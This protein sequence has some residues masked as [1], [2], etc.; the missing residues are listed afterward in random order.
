[1]E[2]KQTQLDNGLTIIGEVSNH[3]RSLALG[4]FVRTGARDETA[5][6]SG[7]SHFLEHMLFKGTDKRSALEVNLEFDEMGAK[8]NAFTTEEN[9]VYFAAVLPEYQQRVLALWADLMRPALRDDDF[10]IEKGVILEEIAMYKDLPHFDIIDHARKLHFGDHCCGHTVL[11]SN[12]SITALTAGQM[13]DYFN[14]RYAPDNIVLAC[15]GR[16]DWPSL[17]AQAKELCGSW[18]SMQSKRPLSTVTGTGATDV[19]H[20]AKLQRQH[21]CLVCPAPSEQD[22]LRYPANILS[23]VLGDDSGSRLYWELIDTALADSADMDYDSMDGAGV[24]YTYVSC[25]PEQTSRV[26]ETIRRV[27]A[28]IVKDGVTEQELDAAKNKIASRATLHGELP[29]GRLVPLG[30]GW[31]YRREYRPLADEITAICAVTT[32]DLRR[33]L[34]NYPLAPL[35]IQTLGP[36]STL[37]A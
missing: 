22:L 32:A 36:C 3:A 33:L 29:M 18:P 6:I 13:R 17:I 30:F 25:D 16:L 35:A 2:F 28:D 14:R 19:R 20:D 4:F 37:P 15:T 8:Y 11:G 21:L 12:E 23:Y 7:V 27:Y 9:T 1:M 26:L 24:Y 31:V 34:D 5:D 10:T